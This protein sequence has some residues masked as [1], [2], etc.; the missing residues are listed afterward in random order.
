MRKANAKQKKKKK[1]PFLYEKFDVYDCRYLCKCIRYM[2]TQQKRRRSRNGVTF[3]KK[4][5]NEKKIYISA[6]SC[7]PTVHTHTHTHQC[8]FHYN[9]T[10]ANKQCFPYLLSLY[11]AA[12]ITSALSLSRFC[13]FHTFAFIY[14]FHENACFFFRLLSH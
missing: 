6:R 5:K 1:V 4:K 7:L 14:L 8:S 2:G 3:P 12:R 9:A 13:P 10:L 11:L